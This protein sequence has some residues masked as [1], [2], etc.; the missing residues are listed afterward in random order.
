MTQA[1]LLVLIQRSRH[2]RRAPRA[3]E[4]LTP[5]S[6][7]YLE[8]DEFSARHGCRLENEP[9]IHQSLSAHSHCVTRINSSFVHRVINQ[10]D[11]VIGLSINNQK[12]TTF[13]PN[14]P[15][16]LDRSNPI[17][18]DVQALADQVL[19]PNVQLILHL[20]EPQAIFRRKPCERN[21]G[22]F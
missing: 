22:H 6:P 7:A 13:G 3:H 14:V 11:Y 19:L 21:T 5:Q 12:V 2:F 17:R 4:G 9:S 10:S 8:W 1:A 20:H 16:W 18:M 15:A